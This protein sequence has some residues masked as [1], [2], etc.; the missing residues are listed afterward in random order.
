[1]R[2]GKKHVFGSS[3]GRRGGKL[4][5]SCLCVGYHGITAGNLTPNGPVVDLVAVR[6]R[7]GEFFAGPG[8]WNEVVTS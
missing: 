8:R 1:M 7:A 6:V 4:P 2:I 5:N 3:G